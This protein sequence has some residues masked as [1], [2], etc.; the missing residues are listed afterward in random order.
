VARLLLL[1][2]NAFGAE[3]IDLVEHPLQQCLSRGAGYACPLEL[4]DLPKVSRL[5]GN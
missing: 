4:D 3:V 2:P 5:V 1:Q